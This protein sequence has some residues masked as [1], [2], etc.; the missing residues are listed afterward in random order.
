MISSH[1]TRT[2]DTRPL[3][4]D[5]KIESVC[6]FLED[7]ES[8]FKYKT[9]LHTQHPISRKSLYVPIQ[10]TRER[11]YRHEVETFW[12]Y[13]ES[14]A[15]LKRAYAIKN[16]DVE[17]KRYRVP[18]EQAKKNYQRLMVLAD[19]GMGK[20][21]LLR[22]E[23]ALTA[24]SERQKLVDAQI[25]VEDVVFPLFIRL[26]DLH[27]TADD[28]T[29]AIASLVQRDYPTTW[30]D[31]Q[32]WLQA[33]LRQGKCLLLFNALDEVPKRDRNALA[34]KLNQFLETHPCPIICTSRI[35]GY[36]GAFING[37]KEVEIIPLSQ[38]QI[39]RFI[40]T[41][42]QY[43]TDSEK[44]GISAAS[45]IEQLRQNPQLRGLAQNPRLLYLLCSLYYEQVLTLPARR[46]QIYQKTVEYLLSQWTHHRGS[47]S[48]VKIRLLE[49][50]AY[51]FTCKGQ[52]VFD[53]QELKQE[54]ANALE[55]D[56]GLEPLRQQTPAQLL[57]QL[58]GEQG[59]LHRLTQEGDRYVFIHRITQD[60]LTACYLQRVIQENPSQGMALVK[61]H[62]WEY[63]WHQSISLL[64]GLMDDP[65]PLFQAI[66]QE[67]DDIF[68][69]L[70]LLTGRAIAECQ[71]LSH[72]LITEVID[73]IYDLWHHYPFVGF[74]AST[75]V[76]L[77]QTNSQM[78]ETLQ[79]DLD[80]KQYYTRK[81]FVAALIAALGQI[82]SPSA[83]A[84]LIKALNQGPWYVRGEAATALGYIGDA[85]TVKALIPALRDED[86]VVRGEAA[87][88]MGRIGTSAAI[89]ALIIALHDNDSYVRGEAA[90]ALAQIGTP[91]ALQELVKVLNHP[92]SFVRWQASG[93]IHLEN[94]TVVQALIQALNH[95]QDQIREEAAMVLGKIATKETLEALIPALQDA[96]PVVREEAAEALARSGNPQTLEVLI[97]ALADTDPVVRQEA[98]AALG[99]M[100]TTPALTALIPILQDQDKRVR[101]Q[102][103]ESL[104]RMGT[105]AALQALIPLLKDGDGDIRGAT[106]T[107]LGR[108]GTAP[109]LQALMPLLKD[110]DWF[111][112]EQ[113]AMALSRIGTPQTL[114]ALLQF[115]TTE[116]ER[117]EILTLIRT[118]AV[119][120]SRE[121]SPLVPVYPELVGA[122]GGFRRLGRKLSGKR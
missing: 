60:Y 18:W 52:E 64:A 40:H 72:P 21:A 82:G 80:E 108:I 121:K 48:G 46:S 91:E 13:A 81:D 122:M 43:G 17:A 55:Q 92:D 99:R 65:I 93:A 23:A 87:A 26:V 12:G 11:N 33:K 53:S 75:V 119:R 66:V 117:P 102:G 98:A 79:Q 74:I 101:K 71:Q 120:F 63:D 39:E 90:M 113:A 76:A 103:I 58:S 59:I 67:K 31:I 44:D 37:A 56:Q 2:E 104:G 61:A 30:A 107:A 8:H 116:I 50:L 7:I 115:P 78:A 100:G 24:A 83:V 85:E 70:L 54:I 114:E 25:T 94:P 57:V 34:T 29:V 69:T 14:E 22:R 42:F 51:Q 9:L 38:P 5:P 89:Q 111:V 35:V 4:R 86:S 15:E 106:A 68:S 20:S 110:N 97:P 45:L 28:I 19:P 118:L 84:T 73:H 6:R 10:V 36:G 47:D 3:N 109:A 112:R 96:D 95:P 41:W 16:R 27:E 1:D 49:D 32:P 62:L 105:P 88:A 77:G